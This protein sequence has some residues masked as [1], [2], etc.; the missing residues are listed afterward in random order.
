MGCSESTHYKSSL[1]MSRES[2]LDTCR[3]SPVK[4]I[5]KLVEDDILN[6]EDFDTSE[7]AI[8]QTTF[9]FYDSLL[10]RIVTVPKLKSIKTST[11]LKRRKNNQKY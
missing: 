11:I 4:T 8:E 2:T 7:L 9:H 3:N 10:K 5:I 1:Q 6:F